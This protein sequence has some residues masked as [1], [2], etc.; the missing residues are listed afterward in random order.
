MIIKYITWSIE[1][2]FGRRVKM[3]ICRNKKVLSVLTIACLLLIPLLVNAQAV[4]TTV[5]DILANPDK[6][7]GKMVQVEGKVLSPKFKTSKKGNPYTTFKVS[8]AGNT[9]S[10][11]SFGTLSDRKSVV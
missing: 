10:V 8:D 4:K 3:R 1:N 2:K 11:F 7:D 6:Y 9:L 5:S